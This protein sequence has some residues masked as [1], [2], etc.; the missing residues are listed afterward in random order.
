MFGKGK[1]FCTE[2]EEVFTIRASVK[3]KYDE[4]KMQNIT[5]TAMVDVTVQSSNLF[6]L[7][8]FWF[9]C[10]AFEF[11]FWFFNK[12]LRKNKLFPHP[13]WTDLLPNEI[14]LTQNILPIARSLK[15]TMSTDCW[16]ND[17]S[18]T[19]YRTVFLNVL[20]SP[21]TRTLVS[22]QTFREII[23]FAI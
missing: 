21:L 17:E 14:K 19:H 16:P 5:T 7:F 9:C 13:I 12:L 11:L 23:I 10:T 20:F 6:Y 18:K 1:P 15:Q 8:N 22:D 4:Q 2:F 3:K